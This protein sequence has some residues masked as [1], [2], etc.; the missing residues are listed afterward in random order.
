MWIFDDYWWP[1]QMMGGRV[2][3]AQGSKV[4]E[5][6]AA[7]VTGPGRHAASDCG[8]DKFIAVLA[9]KELP[10]GTVDGATLVDL[11]GSIR[12]GKLAWEVPAGKWK[13]MTFTWAFKG[14][15]GG[16]QK[17]ISVDGASPD[18]VDWFI[19]A[20]YQPHYDRFKEDFGKTIA[21][22]FYDE[23]ETQG[24]WGSDLPK[25]MAE[26][27]IDLKKSLVAYKYQLAGDEQVAGRYSFLDSFAEAWGRTMYGGMTRWCREHKV[28]SQ[29]HFMEHEFFNQGFN[30]GNVMQLMKYS[31]RGG[32]DLVCHQLYPGQRPETIYQTPKI[33]S[34]VSHIYGGEG[35]NDVAFSEI[36]GGYDQTLTYP[37]MKWLADWH[38]VRGV[39]YLI[40]HSFNPR[41]PSIATIRHISTTADS[42]RGGR[43]TRCGRII[44]RASA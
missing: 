21:G 24:D 22:Y 43:S 20:V 25:W 14:A 2:P 35:N 11:A 33:A 10:D 39:N 7:T 6:A 42:S 40:P 23:P 34:S 32:I 17:Y 18:C 4:L 3:Q 31:D 13:V 19:K 9:G 44:R 16:Q 5:S 26:H 41:A 36:F 37:N 12:D 27:G 38:Q 30:A 28:V 15:K 8:G 1:S 29:G